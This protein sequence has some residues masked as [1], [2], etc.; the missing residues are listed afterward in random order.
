MGG[1]SN[2]MLAPE[3]DFLIDA[4]EGAASS[5]G[6]GRLAA[7]RNIFITH[8]H[9][10]HV[11]GLFQV[12]NLRKRQDLGIPLTIWHPASQKIDSIRKMVGRGY[13]WKI[14]DPKEKI[15]VSKNLFIRPF[16]VKHRQTYALGFKCFESRT[17]RATKFSKY[18]SEQLSSLVQ[19]HKRQGLPPPVI[20][21][22]YDAH[23]FTYTG[24]TEPLPPSTLG[25]PEILMHD[26]TY[27]QGMENEAI[28]KGHSSLGHALSAKQASGAKVL[29][30]LHVSPQHRNQLPEIEGDLIP[31][32]SL[33][34]LK[35]SVESGK[36]VDGKKQ[37]A[38]KILH[39]QNNK[40]SERSKKPDRTQNYLGV[41]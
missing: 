35:F 32:P 20:S 25:S 5:I 9:W 10:D 34:M 40:K 14:A 33:S 22:P 28:D 8:P 36:L 11:A 3:Y 31:P 38:G 21:E 1:H 18:T 26:A 13:D 12:L 7:L 37:D 15:P 24:D 17:R 41:N 30:A 4:G 6:I 19:S 27:L 39:P 16:E 29:V 23:I 2:W